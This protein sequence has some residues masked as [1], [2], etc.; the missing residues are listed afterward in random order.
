MTK[1]IKNYQHMKRKEEIE[2]RQ[3]DPSNMSNRH[4]K[5]SLKNKMIQWMRFNYELLEA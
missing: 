4:A 1:M 3:K 5:F 2:M